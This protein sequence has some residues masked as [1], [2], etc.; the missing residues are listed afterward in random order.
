MN[1]N[2]IRTSFYKQRLDKHLSDSRT[3]VINEL[4]IS[5]GRCRADIAIINGSLIGY[6]I[7]SDMDSLRRLNNQIARYNEVFDKAYLIVTPR[8]VKSVEAILP[9][10]WGLIVASKNQR[11]E[12][13]FKNLRNSKQNANADDFSIAKLL[14]RTEAIQILANLGVQGKQLTE[15]RQIYRIY[16]EQNEFSRIA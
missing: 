3:L 6:E 15:K 12:I 14:W 4:G 2:Q 9:E 11:G 8:Y 10:W 5:H 7:K 13:R 1:D 16:C